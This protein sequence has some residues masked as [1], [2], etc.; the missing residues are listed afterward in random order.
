[1]GLDQFFGSIQDQEMLS[2]L[3][4]AGANQANIGFITSLGHRIYTNDILRTLDEAFGGEGDFVENQSDPARAEFFLNE[5]FAF[6][7]RVLDG[8]LVWDPLHFPSPALLQKRSIG[9][10]RSYDRIPLCSRSSIRMKKQNAFPCTLTG[11][12]IQ[13]RCR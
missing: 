1:N 12:L 2:L 4:F 3:D 13:R 8:A 7:D 10:S 5:T 9:C 11:S 6:V